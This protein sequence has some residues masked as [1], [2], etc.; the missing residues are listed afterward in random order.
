MGPGKNLTIGDKEWIGDPNIPH[1]VAG[2]PFGTNFP[3]GHGP[4]G[5]NSTATGTQRD[6]DPFPSRA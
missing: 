5:S 3:H 6:D 2:S 1:T 4:A